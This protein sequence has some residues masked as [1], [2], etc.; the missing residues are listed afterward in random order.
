MSFKVIT[1]RSYLPEQIS[2]EIMYEIAAARAD[3]FEV[4]RIN[5]L[6]EEENNVPQKKRVENLIRLLK[7]MKNNGRIQ[8]YATKESFET[9]GTEAVFLQNKYPDVFATMPQCNGEEV[10]VYVKI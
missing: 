5:I 10:Y 4:I 6:N 1:L 8:F 7:N 3:R 2:T 9:F